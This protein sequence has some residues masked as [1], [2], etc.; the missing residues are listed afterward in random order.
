MP[1][2]LYDYCRSGDFSPVR[3]GNGVVLP[4]D[5]QTQDYLLCHECEDR[6]NKGG[7]TWLTPKLATM[8]R[9]FPFYDLLTRLPAAF[10][11]DG[12]AFYFAANNPDI[13]VEKLTQ[14]AMGLFW[15]A[16]VHSWA[17]QNKTEPRI[18]LG[19]YSETTRKW[20]LGEA[21]F[22]LHVYLSMAVSRPARAQ[23]TFSEPREGV[24]H[25]D[26]CY[27]TYVP[28]ILFMISVGKQ[29]PPETLATCLHTNPEHPIIISDDLTDEI[30]L[31]FAKSFLQ[32][33]KTAAFLRSKAKRRAKAHGT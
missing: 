10:E 25:P 19:P 16:S 29:A 12:L 6:F 33:R 27:F 22:P 14:F 11:E 20:L 28:G 8:D 32:S 4:T 26:R 9:T 1:A 15:K 30:E 5:R 2:A 17:G 7:E 24:G 31:L 18:E 21:N 3:V 13:K 23:I